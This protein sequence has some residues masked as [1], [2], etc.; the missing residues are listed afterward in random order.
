MRIDLHVHTT[1]SID[2]ECSVGEAIRSAQAAGLDGFA[3]TDHN[4]VA[5]HSEARK[6]SRKGFLII[7]GIEISSTHGHIVGLGVEE[8]IPK[9]LSPAETVNKI[10]EQGGVAI[11]AHP[12]TLL[13]SPRLMYMAKFDAMEVLNARAIFPSN[14]IAKRFAQMHKIAGVAGSD[15]H[16]CDEIGLAY[17]VLNC[18]PNIDSVLKKIKKGETSVGGRT[19]PLPSFLWRALQKSLLHR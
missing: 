1:N 18:E 2:G 4:T 3:I 10:R 7:P 19:L 8:L 16:R 12:F 6:L 17:T 9:C 15:S 5:G 13:R 14:P 11:A